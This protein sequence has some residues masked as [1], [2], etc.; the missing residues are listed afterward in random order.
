M[1][2]VAGIDHTHFLPPGAP[3]MLGDEI[4]RA[5]R[6]VA[7]HEHVRVHRYQIVD[8]IEQRFALGRRRTPDVEVDNVG[9]Q[10]LGGDLESRT[11]T[12]R[13]LEKQIEDALAAQ[14]RYFLHVAVRNFEKT[15]CRVQ[16]AQ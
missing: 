3:Q 10:T 9:G 5:R 15:L 1:A 8:G 11:R 16:N 13:V 4:G 7:N 12:R 14:Q 6:G 2:P